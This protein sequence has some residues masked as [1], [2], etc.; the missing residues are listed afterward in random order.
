MAESR[1]SS[2]RSCSSARSS[3][4]PPL[5]LRRIDP[6]EDGDGG[7]CQSNSFASLMGSSDYVPGYH[8]SSRL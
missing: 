7:P 1:G 6:G 8:C 5:Q 4:S 2:P 3:R